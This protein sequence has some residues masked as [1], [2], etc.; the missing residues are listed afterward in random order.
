MG[1]ETQFDWDEANIA[2]LAR[3]K[4]LPEEAEQVILKDPVEVGVEIVEGEDRYLNPDRFEQAKAARKV[5]KGTVAR[6]ARERQPNR[7]FAND[8]HPAGGR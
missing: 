6:V 7:A 4:V 2:H 3:H 5:G 8:H 1:P